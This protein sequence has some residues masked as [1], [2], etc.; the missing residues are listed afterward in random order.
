[1]SDAPTID[2][3]YSRA[4][5]SSNLTVK[6]DVRSDADVLIAAGLTPGMLGHALMRLHG[7]WDAAAKPQNITQTDATL[8]YG[9]LKSLQRVLGIVTA[10]LTTKGEGSPLIGAKALVMYW[11]DGKCQPCGGR[12]ALVI[13]GAPVLGRSCKACGGGKKRAAPLGE[14]GRKTLNMMDRSVED[15]RRSIKKR[16]RNNYV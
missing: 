6:A 3:R 16:L 7:E 13:N 4:N 10:Y 8:L 5:N 1:M 9:R 14:L 15:A 11:L 12:G 2:E